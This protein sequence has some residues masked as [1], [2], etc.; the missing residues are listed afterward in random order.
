MFPC[1][2][3][4][5]PLVLHAVYFVLLVHSCF[6]TYFISLWWHFPLL[7]FSTFAGIGSFAL[8]FASLCLFILTLPPSQG[9]TRD[10]LPTQSAKR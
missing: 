2:C 7:S 6:T 4:V 9:S 10:L 8:A 3:W 5:L 1:A